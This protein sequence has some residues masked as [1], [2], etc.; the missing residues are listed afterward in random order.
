MKKR[1]YVTKIMTL[2]TRFLKPS[3]NLKN[4]KYIYGA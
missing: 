2:G 1:L 3:D 4:K